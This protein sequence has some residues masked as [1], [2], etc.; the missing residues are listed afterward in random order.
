VIFIDDA[1]ADRSWDVLMQLERTDPNHVRA[2]RL[3][4]NGGQ[5][6]A[7]LCGLH[8]ARGRIIV[9]MDDDLQHPPEEIHRLIARLIEG[10]LD[11]VYGSYR[12]KNHS[13]WRNLGSWAITSFHRLAFQSKVRFSS[14]RAFRRELAARILRCDRTFPF[15]DGLLAA[16]TRRIGEVEVEHHERPLG[17][18]GY[19]FRK[20]A[21]LTLHLVCLSASQ[22]GR[23][24]A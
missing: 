14:F 7:I 9:T 6:R 19:S 13:G 4:Q 5:H 12:K 17:A 3:L 11:L 1:S 10:D 21:Q 8:H 15:V 24:S 23:A 22:R 2:V 18:S 16:N 20:L